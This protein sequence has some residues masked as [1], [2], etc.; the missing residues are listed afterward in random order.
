MLES[1]WQGTIEIVS[2]STI[3]NGGPVSLEILQSIALKPQGYVEERKQPKS[4]PFLTETHPVI[5]RFTVS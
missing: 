1:N 2:I 4:T 3:G 5:L